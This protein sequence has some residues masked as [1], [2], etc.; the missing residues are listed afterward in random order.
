MIIMKAESEELKNTDPRNPYIPYLV[1]IKEITTEN[2]VNDLKT[3]KLEFN[4]PI[5]Q[6]EFFSKFVPGQ[7]ASITIFGVGES[8][9]GIASSPTEE[10][11]LLFT[12][13]KV[14]RVTTRL[15]ELK[16]GRVIGIRG[17]FGN[18]WPV[19]EMKGKNIVIAAGGFAFTTLRSL[20]YYVLAHRKDYGDMTV[21]YGARE[22]SELCYKEDLE[23][24]EGMDGI[25]LVQT[26]DREFP[27]WTK[28]V[29]FVPTVCKEVAPSPKNAV[30]AVCGPPIMIRF[31][32]PVLEELGFSDDQ[33]LLSLEMRMKCG[34]GKCGRCNIGHKFVCIDGPVFTQAELKNLPQGN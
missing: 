14:G 31:T 8:P 13:K 22:P 24:W 17:P 5:D 19:E 9:I 27:N 33:I 10:D 3:F 11:Y 34:I 32:R 15:H 16:V 12:I 6:K 29:G 28:R 2:D 30:I 23:K 26:V 4:D 7:F 1:T 25:N 20:I 18:G 21:I